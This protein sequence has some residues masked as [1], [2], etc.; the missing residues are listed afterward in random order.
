MHGIS[1][2]YIIHAH[3]SSQLE[4]NDYIEIITKNQFTQG[5]SVMGILLDQSRQAT[6]VKYLKR[7]VL[8]P[9]RIISFRP[10][11]V[12]NKCMKFYIAVS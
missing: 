3:V 1:V 4:P 11:S 2:Y 6:I 9:C 7:E 8:L 12:S 5:S 10:F